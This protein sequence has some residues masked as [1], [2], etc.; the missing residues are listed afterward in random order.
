MSFSFIPSFISCHHEGFLGTSHLAADPG[1]PWG[2][3]AVAS[4]D[5]ELSSGRGRAPGSP[6]LTMRP[7]LGAPKVGG[8]GLWQIREADPPTTTPPPPPGSQQAGHRGH[9]REQGPAQLLWSQGRASRM[10]CQ[11]ASASGADGS[12]SRCLSSVGKTN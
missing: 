8:L 3:A 11:A 10:S 2:L 4:R 12:H 9:S 5:T 7:V 6:A 1:N